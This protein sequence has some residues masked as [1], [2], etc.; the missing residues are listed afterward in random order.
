MVM[1]ADGV[2]DLLQTTTA[3]MEKMK[4]TMLGTRQ[5]EYEVYPTMFK[6]GRVDWAGGTQ[7]EFRVMYRKASSASRSGLYDKDS[8]AQQNVMTHGY[9]PMRHM[10]VYWLWDRIELLFNKGEE[11]IVNLMKARRLAAM[12]DLVD[13]MEDDFWGKPT[14]SSDTEKIFGCQYWFT[15]YTTTDGFDASNPTGFTGGRA[16]IDSTNANYS[17][18]ANWVDHF[19]N[20]TYDDMI[21]AMIDTSIKTKFVSPLTEAQ[22]RQPKASSRKWYT[23]VENIKGL[24]KV[25][26]EQNDQVGRDLAQYLDTFLFRGNPVRHVIALDA[27]NDSQCPIYA[28]NHDTFKSSSL[29]GNVLVES[30]PIRSQTY[31]H[32]VYETW[33]DLSWQPFCD[34]LRHNGT[35]VKV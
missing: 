1:Q 8:V 27:E 29:K 18:W 31:G 22:M 6:K 28:I 12:V 15:R 3:R 32:N 11:E 34:D 35:I 9:I 4:F 33:V 10:K 17:R 19:S 23:G 30:A 14:D 26:R 24:A 7:H 5:Q 13:L 16:N 2:A 25:A 21:D 20:Y